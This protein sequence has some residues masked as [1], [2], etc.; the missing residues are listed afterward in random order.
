MGKGNFVIA[1]LR[2][3]AALLLGVIGSCVAASIAYWLIAPN[4]FKAV[5]TL[6]LEVA[7][8]ESRATNVASLVPHSIDVD[9]LRSER[10]AQRV[11]ENEGLLQEPALRMLYLQSIDGGR[12]PHEALAQYLA[13]RVE[14]SSVGEGGV[15][16]LAVTMDAPTLAARVANAYA[17]A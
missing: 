1:I 10:V 3:R 13:G 16:H 12:Q 17:Q 7:S 14:A 11:V 6:F 4:H 5:A 9:L 2:T 15:V 8:G